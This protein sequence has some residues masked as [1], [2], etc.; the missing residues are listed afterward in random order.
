[1]KFLLLALFFLIL[2]AGDEC[3]MECM[4]KW[5]RNVYE[6]DQLSPDQQAVCLQKAAVIEEEC[7]NSCPFLLKL[8]ATSNAKE[9]EKEK[10][11]CSACC[12]DCVLMAAC[13]CLLP[14]GYCVKG[15]CYPTTCACGCQHLNVT[16][17]QIQDSTMGRQTFSFP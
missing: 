8:S 9:K 17:L 15:S 5:A 4:A 2:V 13:C 1:M 3:R 12:G 14:T 16:Y 10:D 11:G 7:I 6:C